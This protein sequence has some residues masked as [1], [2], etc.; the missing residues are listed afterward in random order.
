M[1][2]VISR[3]AETFSSWPKTSPETFLAGRRPLILAPHPDDESLGCGGL[4]AAACAA[5]LAPEVLILTDGAGSHPG[6]RAYPPARLAELREQEA[7]AAARQL[8]L[9]PKNLHFL[10][11]P[12]TELPRRGPSFAAAVEH[13]VALAAA[14]KCR[15][16]IGPWAGDPHA[17][18]L[19]GAMIAQAAARAACIEL[20]S[21]PVWGWLRPVPENDTRDRLTGW[22]LDIAP[23]LAAK[24]R[25]IAAHVSQHGALITDSPHGFTLPKN[26]LE[27]AARPY[28]VLIA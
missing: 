6:S 28:E 1:S 10:R 27:I 4:I 22:R 9:P 26:L 2:A 8:G 21:Y 18:H 11:Y 15:L 19:A 23:H 3:I 17:D 12:D 14:K 16:I 24:Q 7:R 5:H 20:V 25:A 13:V